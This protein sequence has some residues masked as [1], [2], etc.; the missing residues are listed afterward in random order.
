MIIIES[1]A[2]HGLTKRIGLSKRRRMHKV[3]SGSPLFSLGNSIQI[4]KENDGK[5]GHQ[6]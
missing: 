5:Y 1:M 4:I 3:S 6:F 2:E